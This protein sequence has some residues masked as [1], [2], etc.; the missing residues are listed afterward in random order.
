LI[1]LVNLVFLAIMAVFL[2]VSFLSERAQ[3]YQD[4]FAPL[5]ETLG[6]ISLM[7]EISPSASPDV[8]RDLESRLGEHTGVPH[9]LLVAADG[10]ISASSE[11]DLLGRDYRSVVDL[12]PVAGKD[13][14]RGL[15]RISGTDWLVSFQG[16]EDSG[17]FLMRSRAASEG[18]V[19]KF[20]TLHGVHLILTVLAFVLLLK[21]LMDR[22]VRRRIEQLVRHVQRVEMGEFRTAPQASGEAELAWLA[23]RFTRMAT[24]LQTTV[25]HLVR[26]EKY[27]SVSAV[28][29]RIAREL[30]APLGRMER[31]LLELESVAQQE[32]DLRRLAAEMR[33]DRESLIDAIRHLREIE[34]PEG[35]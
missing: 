24:Q 34:P 19:S 4:T 6:V 16:G 13:L 10:K 14:H 5:E 1:L 2:S 9:R 33:R 22:Y 25:E 8:I 28:T 23:E 12:T 20:L 15:A 17:L 27:S 30:K 32:P 11:E 18:F 7:P 35:L 29:F 3:H 26:D 31:H 21:F